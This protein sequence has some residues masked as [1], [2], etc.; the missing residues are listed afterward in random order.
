MGGVC[1]LKTDGPSCT[2][3]FQY[4][5]FVHKGYMWLS[6]E[7]AYQAL[8]FEVGSE[9]FTRI[10]EMEPLEDESSWDFG[11]RAW[12]YGQK[13][14]LRP[15]WELVKLRTM[16]EVNLAKFAYDEDLQKELLQTGDC[17]IIGAP[18]TW[19]WEKWNGL[20]MMFIRQKLI[21]CESLPIVLSELESKSEIEV[22]I[23]LGGTKDD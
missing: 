7:Q 3:N 4:S 11:M 1:K 16:L 21:D 20:I 8:K 9:W 18:S 12:Q 19:E 15:E 10:H 22:K 14:R 2:D 17:E 13:G 5:K 23:Y 6:A